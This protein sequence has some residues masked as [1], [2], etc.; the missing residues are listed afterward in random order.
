MFLLKP[1]MQVSLR[2]TLKSSFALFRFERASAMASSVLAMSVSVCLMSAWV[3]FFLAS[4]RCMRPWSVSISC[5]RSS[6][7]PSTLT[8]S[9]WQ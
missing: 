2:A 1:S 9:A 6:I 7:S 8:S 3:S 4:S 5:C